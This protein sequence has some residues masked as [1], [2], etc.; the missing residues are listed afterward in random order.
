MPI[1]DYCG[2]EIEF[3]YVDK[4][5]PTPIHVNGGWCSGYRDTSKRSTRP[6]GSVVSY[7]NPNAH[8]PECGAQ[9]YFYQS[10]FGGRVF[11][12]DLGW[13]WP[14]HP[15]TDNSQAQRAPI[16]QLKLSMH[17]AF[18]TRAGESL[19]VF[20][21]AEMKSEQDPIFMKLTEVGQSL[22][23]LRISLPTH[24]LEEQNVTVKDLRNAP[25]FVVRFYDDHRLIE[26][27]SGR[28]REIV[29]LRVPR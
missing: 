2:E 12:D 9:V 5:R 21:L 13:P 26:F 10:P 14:K 17:K 6:F 19:R 29:S 18:R 4:N 23:A 24:L 16:K 7:V 3:R 8:C 20:E 28:R 1:C 27:I 11:F 22:V 25:S 15:C